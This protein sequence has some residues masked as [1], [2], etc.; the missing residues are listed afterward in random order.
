MLAWPELYMQQG[1][2]VRSPVG[3]GRVLN[4]VRGTVGLPWEGWGSDTGAAPLQPGSLWTDGRAAGHGSGLK[5][6][7]VCTGDSDVHGRHLKIKPLTTS[8]DES[9]QFF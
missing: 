4:G 2:K 9:L 6:G 1:N 7:A 5:H 8:S 3:T